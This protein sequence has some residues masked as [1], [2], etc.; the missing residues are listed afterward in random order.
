MKEKILEI[1]KNMDVIIPGDV[2]SLYSKKY[3][4]ISLKNIDIILEELKKEDYIKGSARRGY[5]NTQRF[6]CVCKICKEEFISHIEISDVCYDCNREQ[7]VKSE[8]QFIPQLR[9]N[10]TNRKISEKIIN[11][12]RSD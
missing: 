1:I 3:E 2:A 8:N 6:T 10:E 4:F 7:L 11:Q 5:K 9:W 12:K